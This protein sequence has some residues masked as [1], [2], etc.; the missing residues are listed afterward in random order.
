MIFHIAQEQSHLGT[1]M[2]VVIVD[3]LVTLQKFMLVGY[4]YFNL[5]SPVFLDIERVFYMTAL[6][7][8]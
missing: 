2:I 4:R 7:H 5:A 6:E 8:V 1:G 3:V